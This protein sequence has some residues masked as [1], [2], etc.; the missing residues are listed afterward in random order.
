MS[1]QETR[2]P[3]VSRDGCVSTSMP[4]CI[5]DSN[6]R[7]LLMA[8]S[9]SSDSENRSGNSHVMDDAAPSTAESHPEFRV[10]QCRALSMIS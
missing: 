4:E 6:P 5:T 3:A 7:A 10:T 8:S 2:W 1:A 9:D